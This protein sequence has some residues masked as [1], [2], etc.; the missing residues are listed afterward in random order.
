MADETNSKI[1]QGQS[2][3]PLGI[4]LVIA[5]LLVFDGAL[6]YAILVVGLMV[7]VTAFALIMQGKKELE[8]RSDDSR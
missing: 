5:G 8:A 2:L 3:V 6:Q 7:S 1:T 4:V